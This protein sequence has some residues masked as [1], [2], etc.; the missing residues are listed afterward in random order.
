MK[1]QLSIEIWLFG[2]SKF[3]IWLKMVSL[4][5]K[6]KSWEAESNVLFQKAPSYVLQCLNTV[7][8]VQPSHQKTSRFAR[9]MKKRIISF[10]KPDAQQNGFSNLASAIGNRDLRSVFL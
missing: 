1:F 7:Y 10:Q 3:A 6:S 5:C 2:S 8:T 9:S 4:T